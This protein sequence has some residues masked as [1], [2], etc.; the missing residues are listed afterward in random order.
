VQNSQFP[1][2]TKMSQPDP[3]KDF[4]Q[5]ATSQLNN[6]DTTLVSIINHQESASDG[7]R[8]F[9]LAAV[10]SLEQIV[11]KEV[12]IAPALLALKTLLSGG[13]GGGAG[14]GADTGAGKNSRFSRRR[15]CFRRAMGS[16]RR[17]R[18]GN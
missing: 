5:F 16:C 4:D 8:K 17:A 7:W 13:L 2:L 10:E 12:L 11:I 1:G 3:A 9:G 15:R 14:A 18:R 6:M